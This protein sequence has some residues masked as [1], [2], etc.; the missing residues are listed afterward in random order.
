MHSDQNVKGKNTMDQ[1]LTFAEAGARLRLSRNMLYRL[2]GDRRLT[3]IRF[4]RA[5][6]FRAAE[7]D[8]LISASAAAPDPHASGPRAGVGWAA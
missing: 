2:I 1:L 4:G 8:A 5:V 7:V 6:R 3:P